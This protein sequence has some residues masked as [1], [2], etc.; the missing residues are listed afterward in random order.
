MKKD[1]II[2]R[3][4]TGG[5]M[6]LSLT[7]LS[8][9]GADPGLELGLKVW[10][11]D[12]SYSAGQ[13]DT[14]MAG[15]FAAVELPQAFRLSAAV[16]WGHEKYAADS[17]DVWDVEAIL[18]KSFGLFTPGFGVRFWR[19]DYRSGGHSDEYGPFLYLGLG[20][21]IGSWPLR[22]YAAASL[23]FKDYGDRGDMNYY[24]LEAGLSLPVRSLTASL[25]Y[26]YKS[27]YDSREDY[28]YKGPAAALSWRF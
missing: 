7:S 11:A 27:Y 16:L 1:G 4:Q 8:G 20:D 10:P 21:A 28:E 19:N 14:F 26:R 17:T 9:F 13:G 5:L 2:R 25:G 24:L 18:G 23:A 22:W 12:I 15:P 3:A 6:L